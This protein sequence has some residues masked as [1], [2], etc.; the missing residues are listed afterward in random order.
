L[1][2][3][4][5]T[6]LVAL[7]DLRRQLTDIESSLAWRT[8]SKARTTKDFLVPPGTQRRQ[9]YD[10]GLAFLKNGLHRE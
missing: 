10:L 2:S 1:A 7:S 8:I 3:E 5:D 9:F 6:A 4:R